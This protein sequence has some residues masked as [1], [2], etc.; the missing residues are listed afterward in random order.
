MGLTPMRPNDDMT[1]AIHEM[2]ASPELSA[3]CHT[4]L[5]KRQHVLDSCAPPP[6][7]FISMDG[8][9]AEAAAL[10]ESANRIRELVNAL[11]D[12]IAEAHRTVEA[13]ARAAE[14]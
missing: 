8:P 2:L 11:N 4:A 7:P 12:S 1:T 13:A 14:R 10:G 9:A 6:S 3:A 5:K